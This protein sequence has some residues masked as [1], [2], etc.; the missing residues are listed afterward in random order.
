[1]GQVSEQHYY[2]FTSSA[3]IV[4]TTYLSSIKIVNLNA[5]YV[6]ELNFVTVSIILNIKIMKYIVNN[7]KKV[8]I[9]MTL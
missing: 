6:V 1:M 5:I 8:Q 4:L 2:W 7:C 9:K 3:R